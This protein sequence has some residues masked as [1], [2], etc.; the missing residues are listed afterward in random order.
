[1]KAINYFGDMHKG[2]IETSLAG[3]IHTGVF[4]GE[5]QTGLIS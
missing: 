5:I 4:T 2:A 3:N 1:M